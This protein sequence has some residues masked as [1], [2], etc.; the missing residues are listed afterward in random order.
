MWRALGV[1][2]ERV[3][4]KE[5]CGF[6]AC[7]PSPRVSHSILWSQLPAPVIGG[8]RY[9][10]PLRRRRTDG[11]EKFVRCKNGNCSTTQS[12]ADRGRNSYER[13]R[14]E[15][16]LGIPRKRFDRYGQDDVDED[17]ILECHNGHGQDC[18][19]EC[20][21]IRRSGQ[22]RRESSWRKAGRV[23]VDLL[24]NSYFVTVEGTRILSW[25]RNDTF[26]QANNWTCAG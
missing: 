26:M 21:R 9:R 2:V 8:R 7:A 1:A 5:A 25:T 19:M 15:T 24:K 17:R 12:C 4:N 3:R 22:T 6:A 23:H 20:G 18:R 16:S 11:K 10:W 13:K 14:P